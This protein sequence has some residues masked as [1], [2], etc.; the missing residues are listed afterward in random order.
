MSE[1]FTNVNVHEDYKDV[2]VEMMLSHTG[3]AWSSITSHTDTWAT[4]RAGGDVVEIR[5]QVVEDVLT[6]APEVAPGSSFVYSNTGYII[7]GSAL[8]RLTGLSWEELMQ[9]ELFTPLEMTSCG[10]GPPD[11]D[12]S[13]QHPWGHYQGAPVDPTS[14]NA[15]NPPSLGPAGTVHCNLNDWSKFVA[16][17]MKLFRGEAGLLSAEQSEHMFE[18]QLNSYGMGWFVVSQPWASG[19]TLSHAGSNAM[20]RALVWAAPELDEAYLAVANSGTEETYLSLDETIVTL[21]EL[22]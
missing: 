17:Q 14:A 8:E 19:A 12:G 1:L 3:G 9:D 21:I 10:F 15:D 18:V 20:N 7:V 11:I 16:E 22:P 5:A 4:M 2:T 13:L 6:E